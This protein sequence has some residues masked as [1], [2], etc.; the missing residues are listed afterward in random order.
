[1]YAS[2]YT[3]DEKPTPPKADPEGNSFLPQESVRLGRPCP[4]DD[5]MQF[6]E[7]HN[8]HCSEESPRFVDSFPQQMHVMDI[9]SMVDM[10]MGPPAPAL[11]KILIVVRFHTYIHTYI[12]AVVLAIVM[13][14]RCM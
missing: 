4:V 1:M 14:V 12:H 3:V 5:D 7:I 13:V 2:T 11:L 8:L 9:A 10:E 6:D